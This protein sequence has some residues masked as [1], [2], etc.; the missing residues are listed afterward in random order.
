MKMLEFRRIGDQG[1]LRLVEFDDGRTTGDQDQAGLFHLRQIRR[2]A[3]EAV[4][5]VRGVTV[6]PFDGAPP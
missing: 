1:T 2:G 5:N 3:K 4:G 6:I